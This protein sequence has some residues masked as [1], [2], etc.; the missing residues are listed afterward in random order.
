[1]P[2]LYFRVRWPDGSSEACYSPST[3]IREFF[4]AGETYT[5]TDFL[6]RGTAGLSRASARVEQKY[7]M[8]CSRALGQLARI[9]AICDRFADN[10]DAVVLV[11]SIQE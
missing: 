2:E 6:A 8:P 7:G 5:L 3:V 1:M 4:T 10:A 11:E 9:K